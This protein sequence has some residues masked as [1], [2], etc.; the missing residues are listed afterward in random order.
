M[1]ELIIPILGIVFVVGVPVVALATHFALRPL[2]NDLAEAL[3]AGKRRREE[4]AA[5]VE[6]IAQLEREGRERDLQLDAL[7]EAERFRRRLEEGETG[8]RTERT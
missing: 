3:G 2:V 5:L 8:G 1:H 6:R 7:E 4:I